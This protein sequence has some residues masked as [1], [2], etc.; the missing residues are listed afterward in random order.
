M[1]ERL[2]KGLSIAAAL[3]VFVIGVVLVIAGQKNTGPQGT[4][5]M[6]IGLACLII[7]LYCYNRKFK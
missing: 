7:L 4:L 5:V 3:I 1:D 6:L 2:K